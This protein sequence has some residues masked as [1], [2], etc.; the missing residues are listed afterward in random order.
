MGKMADYKNSALTA[1]STMVISSWIPSPK[2]VW[3]SQ[4]TA[5]SSTGMMIAPIDLLSA[6]FSDSID[7]L[8]LGL[9]FKAKAIGK[10]RSQIGF[11]LLTNLT[12][13]ERYCTKSDI[14]KIL[15]EDGGE[16][17]KRLQKRGLNLFLD[18]WKGAA[19]HLMDVTRPG[20]NSNKPLS[21]KDREI[22]KE[23]FKTF[24][25]EFDG[26]VQRHKSYNL[27][28]TA[29][30]QLL[31]KEIAFISPLYHR[32]YDKHQGG[33]FSKNVDKYIKYNKQQFDKILESLG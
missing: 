18:G 33:D 26:L 10:P 12:L 25:V 30:R 16:R 27:T 7:A 15:G 5:P 3:A 31:A 6:Y 14:H 4:L 19:A 21:S 22:I 32:F 2:P 9:E 29:L 8:F 24:N 23:K 28:D 20:G 11:F 13:I 17:V 1:I